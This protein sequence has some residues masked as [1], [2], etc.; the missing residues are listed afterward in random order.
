M[1]ISGF[2]LSSSLLL[3]L[4]SAQETPA[5]AS[6][7]PAPLQ[8][9]AKSS[10]YDGKGNFELFGQDGFIF[11]S[12]EFQ[13]TYE[14]KGL[15][16]LTLLVNTF[17][18]RGSELILVPVPS[19][20]IKYAGSLDLTSYPRLDFSS[21][22]FVQSWDKMIASARGTGAHVV[23][24]LPDIL[25]F[26]PGARGEDFF[27]P[28]DHHWTTS[29]A[30]KAAQ[31]T[32]DLIAGIIRDRQLELPTKKGTLTLTRGSSFTGS[33]GKRFEDVCGQ[34]LPQMT[35]YQARYEE[36]NESLL[37]DEDDVIGIF[38]DSFGQGFPD[39]N[40]GPLLEYRT[41]LKTVNYSSA[42]AGPLLSLYGYLADPRVR[43][44]LPKFIVVPFM[45]WLSNNAFDYNQA[46]AALLSCTDRTRLARVDYPAGQDKI[47]FGTLPQTAARKLIHIHTNE[48]TNYLEVRG[49]Y[50]DGSPMR[51][52]NWRVSADYFRGSRN[53]FYSLA[54]VGR[55][56][57]EASIAIDGRKPTAGYAEVCS[58]DVGNAEGALSSP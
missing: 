17:R 18:A 26:K 2:L 23:D 57:L 53:D 45:G 42:G 1:N 38:G 32:A 46:T 25:A 3:G 30:E 28:R 41:G 4:G 24:L 39:S 11:E 27:Y 13:D 22:K 36:E 31:E 34:K 19:R 8:G 12:P 10:N 55:T 43:E 5:K 6:E 47:T 49:K 48:T 37:G 14:F 33:Y 7:I 9:C 44:K 15:D 51:W 29:G 58:V 56:P 50:T 16:Q 54:A 40:F 52:E 21:Q 35:S 20:A